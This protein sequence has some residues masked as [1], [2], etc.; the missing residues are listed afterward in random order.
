[1]T[2]GL[3][4]TQTEEMKKMIPMG[5]LGSPEDVARLAL[6]LGGEESQYITGEVIK[7][8]GGMYV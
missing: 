4:E 8:D 1:M 5:K 6:F 3:S 2:A 7:V